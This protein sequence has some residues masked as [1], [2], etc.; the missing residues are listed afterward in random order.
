MQPSAFVEMMQ[1][2]KMRSEMEMHQRRQER[3]EAEERQ[4]HE[5]KEAE[6]RQRQEQEET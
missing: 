2:M 5:R 3:K 1:F 6:E 4:R